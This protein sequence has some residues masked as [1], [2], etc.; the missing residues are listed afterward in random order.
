MTDYKNNEFDDDKTSKYD[1][2]DG[3]EFLDD[4]YEHHDNDYFS[5]Y[6]DNASYETDIPRYNEEYYN[7]T[8]DS[9]KQAAKTSVGSWHF[10][11]QDLSLLMPRYLLVLWRILFSQVTDL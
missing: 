5:N 2:D 6:D 3:I 11:L 9:Q 10:Y 4:T 1:F 7:D 8:K